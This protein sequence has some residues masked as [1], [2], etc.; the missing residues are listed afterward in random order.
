MRPGS[1]AR[2]R[3]VDVGPPSPRPGVGV[4]AGHSPAA[5]G[6]RG[7]R[8]SASRGDASPRM[9]SEL[10]RRSLPPIHAAGRI[11]EFGP[12]RPPSRRDTVHRR[13]RSWN[14]CVCRTHPRPTVAVA[15]VIRSAS[16]SQYVS[17]QTPR[18]IRAPI[19]RSQR[20]RR[21]AGGGRA[22]HGAATTRGRC[23]R[24]RCARRTSSTRMVAGREPADQQPLATVDGGGAEAGDEQ[25]RAAEEAAHHGPRSSRRPL[26]P[27][28]E[29]DEST[30][31]PPARRGTPRPGRGPPAAGAAARG[32][33]SSPSPRRGAALGGLPSQEVP[34]LR[35]TAA[36]RP[37]GPRRGLL[38]TVRPGA[39][40]PELPRNAPLPTCPLDPQPP[41]AEL[42]AA[43][44]GVVG[45]EGPSPTSRNGG[46]ISAVDAS[47]SLPIRRRAAAATAVSALGVE[48]EE[49]GAG[50]VEQPSI[51][52]ACQ[53]RAAV[54]RVV[55]GLEPDPSSRT[56][57]RTSSGE[58]HEPDQGREGQPQQRRPPGH[59][60]PRRRRPREPRR[61][62]PATTARTGRGERRRGGA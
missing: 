11:T 26:R 29:H 38:G 33:A 43:D 53:A 18:P 14:R 42:V 1:R 21:R 12:E 5:H 56:A 8:S 6:P 13:T 25:E 35:S 2:G 54:H 16:G 51:D 41:A 4:G 50:V 40:I 32:P 30:C 27:T 59:P 49:R 17:H 20:L 60:E 3:S 62:G 39:A 22:N 58:D 61:P 31:E 48:R 55:P 24:A 10:V 47:T 46:S 7:C 57:T 36:G 37:T 52:Q 44:Q 45:E 9:T 15:Q 34:A 23:R 19:E 28:H